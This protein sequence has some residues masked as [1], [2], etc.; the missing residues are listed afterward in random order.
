M[1]AMTALAV[2]AATRLDALRGD[3]ASQEFAQATAPRTFGFPLD[4]GPHPEFRHEWWY[5]TGHL[6]A[7]N[8]ERFGFE[9]TFFRYALAPP[10][11]QIL[12][13]TDSAWRTNQVYL[14]HFAVTDLQRRDF[15][16]A[17][18]YSREA[19]GLAGARSDPLRVW[20]ED[21]SLAASTQSRWTLRA[22]SERYALDLDL[23][24]LMAPVLNGDRGLS[25]K[26]DVLG[27]AS[28]YYSIPRIAVRGQIT[29]EGR[30]VD[31]QGLAWLDREWG[32]GTLGADQ[33]GWD[34]FA[35]QFDD[36]S[37]LM[38]YS[39]RRED[40]TRDPYSAGTWVGPDGRSRALTNEDVE[41]DV[42]NRWTS[43][44]GGI[45]P[46]SWRIR[47]P[48][49]SIDIKVRPLLANQELL[50]NPRYW[51]GAVTVAGQRDSGD[52]A[53]QGYVELVGYS[54]VKRQP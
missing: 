23:Q 21:W 54:T 51:E 46:A 12:S 2:P 1:L 26:S 49:L 44:Q 22:A 6:E 17:E 13:T 43:P 30:P 38:F 28:Y 15:H 20:L 11:S 37:A 18:R 48:S 34:W 27:A 3:A 9:L 16:F 5:I 53:G 36:R 7:Q 10:K 33:Q 8:G 47:V 24:P 32:S 35:L 25:R 50:T 42:L 4:H 14:A 40:G 39:L 29:R 31:V 19:L 41:I 52:L 45:Y